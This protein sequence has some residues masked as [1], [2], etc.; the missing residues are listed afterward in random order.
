MVSRKEWKGARR[1]LTLKEKG[2][3]DKEKWLLQVCSE[4][5]V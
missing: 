3:K 5:Q 2:G 4:L 1:N